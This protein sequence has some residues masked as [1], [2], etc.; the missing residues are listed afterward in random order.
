M[1]EPSQKY[2]TGM[3]HLAGNATPV[4]S[5][6]TRNKLVADWTQNFQKTSINEEIF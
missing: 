2:N 1:F 6:L 5:N 3:Q 4:E